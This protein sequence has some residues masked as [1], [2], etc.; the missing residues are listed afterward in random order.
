METDRMT[1]EASS[2]AVSRGGMLRWAGIFAGLITGY[3]SLMILVAFG[4]TI[5]L[6]VVSAA[7]PHGFTGLLIGGGVWLLAAHA[8]A[9]YL[10]G[11]TTAGA[12]PYATDVQKRFNALITGMLMLL[13]LTF[14]SLSFMLGSMSIIGGTVSSIAG[15]FGGGSKSQTSWAPAQPTQ[16]TLVAQQRSQESSLAPARQVELVD[17]SPI[18]LT[19]A[20]STSSGSSWGEVILRFMLPYARKAAPVA[21][22][23]IGAWLIMAAILLSFAVLGSATLSA[24]PASFHRPVHIQRQRAL[25]S[26]A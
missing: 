25:T 21:A 13:V 17:H 3:V 19:A 12:A 18:Q 10:G 6:L 5:W 20:A 4:L 9:A 2:P 8:I 23:L 26:G 16:P 15:M 14:Y 7:G 22:T 11:R 24:A 1:A